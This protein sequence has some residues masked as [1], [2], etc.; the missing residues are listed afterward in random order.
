MLSLLL[1]G[2]LGWTACER[3][4][5]AAAEN[6][7]KAPE[8]RAPV[9]NEV[10][11]LPDVT[12]GRDQA[13][14]EV[15]AYR[16]RVRQLYN[17][18][19][20]DQL[21]EL[22]A[23]AQT[24]RTQF[25]NGSWLIYQFYECMDPKDDEPESMWQLH[26]QIHRAWIEAKPDSVTARVAHAGFLTTYAWQARGGG[27]ANTVTD[28]GWKLF[29]TRLEE[30]Q[31]VLSAARS[32]PAKC[33]MWWRYQMTVALG[34]GWDRAI[35]DKL[36]A[37][38]KAF[39]PEFWA[40]DIARANYLLPRWHGEEGDWEA[41]AEG[42]IEKPGLGSEAYARVVIQQRGYY[43]QIFEETKASWPKTR[44]G[45]EK[46]RKKFPD[47]DVFLNH[48]ARLACHAGDPALARK[49]FE[50]IGGRAHVDAWKNQK[51]F[52]SYRNWAFS[53]DATQKQ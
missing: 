20:F 53:P 18:R 46:L 36:F 10:A 30:A 50:E 13:S 11:R 8:R 14:E 1:L 40:Y 49:L 17:S 6:S 19:N 2:P 29:E 34:Q 24:K 33:P 5:D 39:E 26:D 37:E 48:Y 12:V 3:P 7:E 9:V 51:T 44:D 28:A 4:A 42:E 27:Y 43:K 52:L 38:A 16:L 47:T 32:L 15:D 23:E 31:K 25:A 35:Y 41:A 21:E 22:A 45:L